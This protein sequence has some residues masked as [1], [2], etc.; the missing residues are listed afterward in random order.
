MREIDQLDIEPEP[1]YLRGFNQRATDAHA[2][3]FETAL[4]V[5]EGQRGCNAHEKIKYAPALLAPPGLMH[6]DQAAIQRAR[7]KTQI[8][9]AAA[10][11]LDQF[12]RF[13]ERR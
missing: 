12:W 9:S 8:T 4:R 3:S 7:A 13:T 11:R 2:K 5:P 10:N 1:I 6:A